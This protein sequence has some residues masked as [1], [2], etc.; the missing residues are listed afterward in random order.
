MPPIFT[1]AVFV[2]RVLPEPVV[3]VGAVVKMVRTAVED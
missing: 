2:V 1:D 3:E